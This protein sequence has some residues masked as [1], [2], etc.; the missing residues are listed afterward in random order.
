MCIKLINAHIFY[1]FYTVYGALFRRLRFSKL[2]SACFA[3]RL[4]CYTLNE[5]D[6]RALSLWSLLLLM[7]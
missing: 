1:G 4:A 3:K 2:T 6:A 7:V 5:A